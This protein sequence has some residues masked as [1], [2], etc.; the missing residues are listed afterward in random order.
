MKA[1]S[2]CVLD[3]QAPVRPFPS[4]PVETNLPVTA[5]RVQ[6]GKALRHSGRAA[7][8]HG[9]CY[10]MLLPVRRPA[11]AARIPSVEPSRSAGPSI[12]PR[13]IG[14]QE[15]K[16]KTPRF[17]AFRRGKST[18]MP[19]APCGIP[20]AGYSGRVEADPPTTPPTPG[21]YLTKKA[22]N[23]GE[24]HQPPH[25]AGVTSPAA[26]ATAPRAAVTAGP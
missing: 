7:R 5:W 25:K 21:R 15:K 18:G 20:A 23:H 13:G 26:T 3:C 11:P 12:R 22:T 8:H 10:A 14:G 19:L 2:L 6:K 16:R 24:C 17:D 1:P 4:L 9:P